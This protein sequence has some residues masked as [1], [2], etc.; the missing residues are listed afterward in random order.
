MCIAFW[1]GYAGGQVGGWRRGERGI[2][3]L[4]KSRGRQN[5]GERRVCGRANSA[6][7]GRITHCRGAGRCTERER[8]GRQTGGQGAAAEL[9]QS[10]PGRSEGERIEH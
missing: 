9:Q 7:R 10:V 4:E 2:L 8:T 3:Q 6:H 1:G 5:G